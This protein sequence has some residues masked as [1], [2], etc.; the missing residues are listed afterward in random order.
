MS[1]YVSKM[2]VGDMPETLRHEAA[3]INVSR[4]VLVSCLVEN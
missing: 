2:A 3:S 1:L 4:G